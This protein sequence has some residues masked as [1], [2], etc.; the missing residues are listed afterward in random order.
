[1]T[2]PA[3]CVS[4][5]NNPGDSLFYVVSFLALALIDSRSSILSEV[6]RLRDEGVKEVTLLGQ[7]VNSWRVL[8][9]TSAESAPIPVSRSFDLPGVVRPKAS[10]RFPDLLH[11]VSLVDPEM[12][13]RFTSPH[14]AHCTDDLLRLIADTPNICSALHLPLQSGSTAVLERMRRRYSA[15]AY[16]DLVDRVRETIP[17]VTISTDIISGFC[18]ETSQDHEDTLAMLEYVEYDQA[19]CYAYSMRDKTE[20]AKKL[21]DDV[22][23]GTKLERLRQVLDLFHSLAHAKNSKTKGDKHLVLVEDCEARCPTQWIPSTPVRTGRSDGNQRV[24]FRDVSLPV[25]DRSGKTSGHRVARSG[26]YVAVRV[27]DSTSLT[28]LCEPIEVT[29]LSRFSR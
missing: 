16:R 2:L 4:G 9:T 25:R 8:D 15:S 26:D 3:L 6:A 22:P 14:P 10:R 20:A 13:V 23:R 1:M 5:N 18:G 29:T 21:V 24:V 28:L 11:A 12:R 27:V 7:N 19:F 17:S